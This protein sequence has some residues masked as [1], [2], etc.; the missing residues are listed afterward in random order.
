MPKASISEDPI[1]TTSQKRILFLNSNL[2]RALNMTAKYRFFIAELKK[3]RIENILILRK[4]LLKI[5]FVILC[6]MCFRS[7]FIFWEFFL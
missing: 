7:G 1:D 3:L 6:S 4:C 2:K 5:L